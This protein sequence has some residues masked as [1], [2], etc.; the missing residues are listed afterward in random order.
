M[1]N[2]SWVQYIL[3]PEPTENINSHLG[4]LFSLA[5]LTRNNFLKL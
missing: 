5:F 1:S 2:A 4:F 3:E